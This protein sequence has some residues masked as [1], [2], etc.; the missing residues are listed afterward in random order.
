MKQDLHPKYYK[1]K[2]TCVCGNV[3]ETGSTLP[4][5]RLD[6]CPKCHPL[7]TGTQKIVDTEGRVQKFEKR[8]AKA[9]GKK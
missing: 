5:I 9:A 6:I 3:V 8:Y 7:F 2:A 1:V 4:E